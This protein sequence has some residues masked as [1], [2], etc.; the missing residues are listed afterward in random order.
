MRLQIF[1]I[2]T[3]HFV[4]GAPIASQHAS[5]RP[6]EKTLPTTPEESWHAPV[7]ELVAREGISP[8]EACT[9]LKVAVGNEEIANL[10]R[11]KG[12]QRLLRNARQQFYMEI[13][14]DITWS[15]RTAVGKMLY[16]VDRLMEN[17]E[18]DKA[19]EGLLKVARVE[20]WL[21]NETQVNVFNNLTD[22][23][24]EG[25]KT[26]A[27]ERIASQSRSLPS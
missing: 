1:F 11:T 25:I 4:L 18:N 10:F 6:P 13:A 5:N 14:S 19:L 17:G 16:L 26:R 20:G 3:I 9:R 21:S 2:R 8:R 22:S 7:A 12:F 24:L 23:E 27:A 15:R